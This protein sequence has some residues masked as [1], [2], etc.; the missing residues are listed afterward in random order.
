M[1]LYRNKLLKYAIAAIAAAIITN[2]VFGILFGLSVCHGWSM[3]PT[4]RDKELVL[5]QRAFYTPQHGD[6]IIV[7]VDGVEANYVKRVIGLPGDT[8]YI[9]TQTAT[10]YRNGIALDEP[11]L[12]TPTFTDG[13]MHGEIVTV[14]DGHV[15]VMGDNRLYSR[16][17]RRTLIGEIPVE[18]VRGKVLT[19]LVHGERQLQYGTYSGG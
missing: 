15:F 19:T 5:F 14:P 7:W 3:C 17:S 1:Y 9:D 13:D 10:V 6:V 8:I 16:D 12:G 18:N 2:I 4:I 11:Y